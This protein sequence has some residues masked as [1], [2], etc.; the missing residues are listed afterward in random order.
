MIVGLVN[1]SMSMAADAGRMPF[2]VVLSGR[3]SWA[4]GPGIGWPT[5]KAR[6][7][8]RFSSQKHGRARP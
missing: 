8:K 4:D 6:E 1:S 3:F 5:R 7:A 2:S